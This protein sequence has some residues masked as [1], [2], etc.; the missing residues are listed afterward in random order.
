MQSTGD[1]VAIRGAKVS[2]KAVK[3]RFESSQSESESSL[4]GLSFDA[5]LSDAEVGLSS[6]FDGTTETRELVG[7]TAQGVDILGQGVY[8][9]ATDGKVVGAGT[10]IDSGDGKLT[11]KGK[12]GLDFTEV[13][14]VQT[15]R[16]S[17]SKD[18]IQYRQYGQ[19]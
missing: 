5:S 13:A 16:L 17:L 3:D 7:E 6:H 11:V 1:T 10:Q 4:S 14:E 12:K 15:A 18:K 19:T 9:E 2:L 8:I